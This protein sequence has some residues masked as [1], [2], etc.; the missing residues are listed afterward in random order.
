MEMFWEISEVHFVPEQ[1]YD[2]SKILNK[3][4]QAAASVLFYE[5]DLLVEVSLFVYRC[6]HALTYFKRFVSIRKV[7][8]RVRFSK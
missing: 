8:S 4:W 5:L 6:F 1:C 2:F 7:M 3:K